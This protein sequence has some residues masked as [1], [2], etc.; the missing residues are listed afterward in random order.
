MDY[1]YIEQLLELYWN[2]ETSQEEERILRAFFAQ[3]RVPEHLARYRDLFVYE[4]RGLTTVRLGADFDERL[5]RLAEQ[6]AAKQQAANAPSSQD[7]AGRSQNANGQRIEASAQSREAIAQPQEVRARRRSFM[8]IVRPL[9]QAA[10]AVAIVMLFV[11]GAQHVF[12]QPQEQAAWDYDINAYKDSYENPR[13]AYE[14]L[15]NGLRE[16]KAVFGNAIADSARADSAVLKAAID[17]RPTV[18]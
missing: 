15:G 18:R 2:C 12:N 3:D 16:L 9:Y 1:R 13:E 5:C 7:A 4:H 17:Q 14:S 6:T 10:A 8:A 11:T